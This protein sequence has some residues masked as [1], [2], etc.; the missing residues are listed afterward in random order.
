MQITETDKNILRLLQDNAGLTFKEI[1]EEL[2]MSHSTVW[3]R[4]QEMEDAGIITG[5]VTLVDPMKVGLSVCSFVQVNIARH[6]RKVRKDFEAFIARSPEVLECFS[7][8]GTHD[9]SLIVRTPT[10]EDF[11][12]FLMQQLLAHPSVATASSNIVL[13][14]HKHTTALPL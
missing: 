4:V 7:I 11:E 9:Y 10:V 3:R 6:D 14:Q 13:R 1:A 2:S 5:R 12:H 8:T